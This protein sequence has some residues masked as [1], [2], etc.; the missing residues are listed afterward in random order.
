M[1]QIVSKV[2][3]LTKS[4]K[5]R[6]CVLFDKVFKMSN[7]TQGVGGR[8][9]AGVNRLLCARGNRTQSLEFRRRRKIARKLD[10]RRLVKV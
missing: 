7:N 8:R 6:V 1:Y 3:N 5:F 4:V 9:A 2:R 10:D